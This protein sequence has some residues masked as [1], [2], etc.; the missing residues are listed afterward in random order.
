[1]P[2]N[3]EKI[4]QDQ[5]KLRFGEITAEFKDGWWHVEMI[6]N[7]TNH[8]KVAAADSDLTKAMEKVIAAVTEKLRSRIETHKKTT[9][10]LAQYAEYLLAIQHDPELDVDYDSLTDHLADLDKIEKRLNS[11][12]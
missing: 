3:A 8:Q 9:E 7:V 5:D 11:E 1:M 2:I 10:A 6:G 12:D 4:L